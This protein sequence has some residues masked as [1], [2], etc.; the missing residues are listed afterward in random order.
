MKKKTQVA[1]KSA[2]ATGWFEDTLA[3]QRLGPGRWSLLIAAAIIIHAATFVWVADAF[4]DMRQNYREQTARDFE[5]VFEEEEDEEPTL[6]EFVD[7]NPEVP[8]NEPDRD[9]FISDRSQQAAQEIPDPRSDDPFPTLD[10]DEEDSRRIVEGTLDSMDLP[11]VPSQEPSETDGETD[12]MMVF[13]PATGE[14]DATDESEESTSQPATATLPP[15]PLR[16]PLPDFLQEEEET[17]DEEGVGVTQRDRDEGAFEVDDP[18]EEV[19]E[20]RV[21]H[22]NPD[23]A[24]TPQAEQPA[25]EATEERRAGGS[26]PAQPFPRPTLGPRA[27]EGPLMQSERAARRV[28]QIAT[29]ATFSEFGEYKQRMM[30][31]IQR[32]WHLLARNSQLR[33]EDSPSRVHVR[34]ILTSEGNV[35]QAEVINTTA[36]RVATIITVD[37]VESRSPFGKWTEE[38]VTIYGQQTEFNIQFI[39]W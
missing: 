24:D 9:D 15:T 4:D 18:S 36:G 19:E 1:S 20:G 3:P 14:G 10:G 37:A 32:Q 27:I 26:R 17:E 23:F 7:T 21:I 29:D 33:P 35:R 30:E 39:Y 8:E 11:P 12:G 16:S 13:G 34:F 31:V 6:P 25:E 5:L 28:G 2:Q 38:M 22:L